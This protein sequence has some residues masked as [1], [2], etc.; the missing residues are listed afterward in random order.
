MMDQTALQTLLWNRLPYRLRGGVI[1]LYED[2]G[3]VYIYK[4]KGILTTPDH[5][6]L[7]KLFVMEEIRTQS[8]VQR[9]QKGKL[10]TEKEMPV[11]FLTTVTQMQLLVNLNRGTYVI[12]FN[13]SYWQLKATPCSDSDTTAIRVRYC[14]LIDITME[15]LDLMYAIVQ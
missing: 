9:Q 15:Q 2:L 3:K 13:C 4:Y 11:N 5:Q 12:A 10:N 7:S 8:L 14:H 1:R 6:I